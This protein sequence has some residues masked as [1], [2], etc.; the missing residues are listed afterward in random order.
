MICETIFSLAENYPHPYRSGKIDKNTQTA[1]RHYIDCIYDN[2]WKK[3]QDEWIIVEGV[4]Q[5]YLAGIKFL[6]QPV[7]LWPFDPA[8]QTQWRDVFPHVL[9]DQFIMNDSSESVLA[10]CGDNPFTGEDP[11]YHSNALGQELI[12]DNWFRRITQEHHVR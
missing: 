11:G 10:V 8:N 7:L 4:L 5:M 1:I 12:A 3:Q 2:H 6:L 9:P